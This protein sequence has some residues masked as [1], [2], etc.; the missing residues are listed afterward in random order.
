MLIALDVRVAQQNEI[1]LVTPAGTAA[2]LSVEGRAYSML[3]ALVPPPSD[4]SAPNAARR[5]TLV[6]IKVT[7]PSREEVR[8]TT[9]VGETARVNGLRITPRLADCTDRRPTPE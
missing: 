7:M 6:S 1:Q 5:P 9:P 3:P 4:E 2:S 8:L